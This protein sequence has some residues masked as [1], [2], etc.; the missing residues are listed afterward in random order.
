MTS[1]KARVTAGS[2]I[3]SQP[4]RAVASLCRNHGVRAKTARAIITPR[5]TALALRTAP[6]NKGGASTDST[7]RASCALR[8]A[9]A[10]SPRAHSGAKAAMSAGRPF[11]ASRSCSI[12]PPMVGSARGC[13]NQ[14]AAP[15][16]TPTS[17]ATGSTTPASIVRVVASAG[18]WSIPWR[19][20]AVS[21]NASTRP[22]IDP[23]AAPSA[24]RRRS[25]S[26][27]RQRL[28]QSPE[29]GGFVGSR[30]AAGVS[31]EEAPWLMGL[32]AT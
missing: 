16:S 2:T 23:T 1:A 25:G 17:R 20:S 10:N 5:L 3:R 28:P 30:S 11:A 19:S 4:L 29:R 21:T 13:T 32:A 18:G 24:T 14:L 26:V 15:T 6:H 8:V 9:H 22:P 7:T 27:R 12:I 31:F